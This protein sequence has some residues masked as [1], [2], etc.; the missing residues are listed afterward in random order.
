QGLHRRRRDADDA[1]RPGLIDRVEANAD[2]VLDM[3]E[4]LVEFATQRAG[5]A[6][7]VLA[8]IDIAQVARGAVRDLSPSLDPSR[9]K[10]SEDDIALARA[11][12][13]AMHRVVTNLVLNALKY[14]SSDAPVELTFTR[15]RPGWVRLSVIDQGRGI[16]PDDL[17]TIFDEFARGRLAEND[18]GS[19]L[20]LA[21][22]RELVEQQDGV[23]AIESK[24][25]VGTT[26]TIDMPSPRAIK[27]AAP[28]QRSK[29][30]S[31]VRLPVEPTGQASG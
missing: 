3:V 22:V 4:A 1:S 30:S 17:D 9:I 20:G 2:R 19:G 29:L 15:S 7:L 14:S 25:G 8:D 6:S 10:I 11:N 5:H 16:D 21:S 12:G 13:V 28:S 26:V 24:V 23:V 31:S 27:P 18:G